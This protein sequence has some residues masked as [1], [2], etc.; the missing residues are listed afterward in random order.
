MSEEILKALMQLFALLTKQDGGVEEKERE[1]VK[2]FLERSISPELVSEYLTLF[3]SFAYDK[4]SETSEKKLTSVKDSVRILG[5]CK[6]I[7][8]TLSQK[9]KIIVII[10][11]YE[12][13]VSDRKFTEQRMAIIDAA[14]EV[15]NIEKNEYKAIEA[16]VK[17]D[18][19]EEL[20][21]DDSILTINNGNH[22]TKERTKTIVATNLSGIV[23]ILKV[24]SVDLY[25]L[26]YLGDESLILNSQYINKNNGYIFSSGSILR[27]P[28]DKPV[29]YSDVVAHFLKDN[30]T[31]EISFNAKNISFIFPGGVIGL[32]NIT[33]SEQQGRLI[34]IMGASGSGKTTLLNVLSGIETPSKGEVL[35]NGINLHTEKDKI[36]GIIGYVPQD[37]VLIEELTVFENLYYNAKFCFKDLSNEEI[38][39]KVD[40][41]LQSLGLYEKKEL[42]VG[43]PITNKTIS[44]GQRKRLNIALE[45]I[46][47]PAILFV[48]EPTSGLSSRDSE[49]IMDLLRELTLDGKLIFSVIH[50]PSSE[51]Y[52]M[53]DK[54]VILD[55]GGYLIYYDNPIEAIRYFKTLDMQVD[56]DSGDCSKC[57][58]VNPE[59]I[60]NI[61]EKKVVDEY[62]HYKP[63]RKVSP[64][65]WEN[66]F[67][68]NCKPEI[69]DDKN[70]TLP[71]LLKV[72]NKIKQFIIYTLRD[73]KSKISNRQYIIINLIE[74]PLLAFILAFIVRYVNED[75]GNSYIYRLNDNIFPYIFIAVI[76]ALFVGMTVS[77]E[78]IFRDRKI[79]KRESFLNLNRNSYLFSKVFILF[80][81]SAIQSLLFV[82]I[83]NSIMG[84]KGMYIDYWLILFSMSCVAVMI[85]L[86]ISAAFNSAVTI[87]ILIPLLIIPQ[88]ILAG[89]TFDFA[90]LNR[91]I[92]GGKEYPPIIAEFIPA[93]WG[94]EALIVQQFKNNK[95]EK[96]F[97]DLN[98]MISVCNYKA[99]FYIPKLISVV[100]NFEVK[101]YEHLNNTET[102]YSISKD[103]I[104][105]LKNEI[106][107][108]LNN[109]ESRKYV[110]FNYL[111]S[112][113]H[114]N[115]SIEIS[116]ILK[117]YLTNVRSFY[118]EAYNAAEARKDNLLAE[119]QNTPEKQEKFFLLRDNYFNEN[120]SD[121]A[122]NASSK[123]K[124]LRSNNNYIQNMERIYQLPLNKNSISFRTH[125]YAP[126][127]YLF[128]KQ[129]STFTLNIIVLWF[130][131]LVLYITLYFNLLQRLLDWKPKLP[132]RKK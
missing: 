49:N 78:E 77:A 71:S 104:E 16:F 99:N 58:N 13:I 29:Y 20:L 132:T 19:F 72:P 73:F 86:N 28:K 41:T 43:S 115:F 21:N 1:Y 98:Q 114:N 113:N 123:N 3:D 109:G 18:N 54:V 124:I 53:F 96:I 17:A 35:I 82:L 34:G 2:V 8:K 7:N 39:I 101:Y 105:L 51:I 40:K 11:L 83:G 112:L 44:G 76:V 88:M 56:K 32:N 107:K 95:F 64:K 46:R 106:T 128:G 45:L 100:D 42:K 75:N 10:N 130:M 37:D 38:A 85:G 129:Y 116:D 111:D 30:I 110:D 67:K 25:F 91:F 74:T 57:G 117:K 48:D 27:L 9:Q 125:F 118:N 119:M 60:F 50:Q 94:F 68:E 89:A 55:T 90:K 59:L 66:N 120:L 84:I 15:F 81:L 62:G 87:Y 33:I 122:K 23:F 5:I 70:S 69:I 47:E 126:V 80:A 36:K 97:Y 102:K 22:Q 6:K 65:V 14:A 108:E 31:N 26:R 92:G 127:K 93:R 79:L 52:K 24:E 4:K 63:E 131:S 121:L 103:D 61:I 12:L